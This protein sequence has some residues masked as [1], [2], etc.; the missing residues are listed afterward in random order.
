MEAS[1]I[2]TTSSPCPVTPS[3]NDSESAGELSRISWPIT[4]RLAS[5]PTRRANA[6]PTSA[7]KVSSSCSST[8]P[9]TSYALITA[10]TERSGPRH[11]AL[12]WNGTV[13][14][15]LTASLGVAPRGPPVPGNTSIGG[16]G[17]NP[18][19]PPAP[20]GSLG[21]VHGCGHRSAAWRS[22]V[23]SGRVGEAVDGRRQ[24]GHERAVPSLHAPLPPTPPGRL[25]RMMGGRS[26][27][28]CR[29]S[30]QPRGAVI[31]PACNAHR[32]HECGSRTVANGPTTAV[33]SE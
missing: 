5:E 28:A 32:S 25:H 8:R 11:T 22:A 24:P 26:G 14:A 1:P 7:T 21:A 16:V 13:L 29:T 27:S 20:S 19:M 6:A 18:Q 10:A 33:E 17:Q 30:S 31:R 15:S 3:A 4:I 12:L 23:A 2:R 9:R